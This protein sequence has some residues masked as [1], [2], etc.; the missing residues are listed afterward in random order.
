MKTM[1]NGMDITTTMDDVVVS[2]RIPKNK[3]AS[4]MDELNRLQDQ[5]LDVEIKKHRNKRSLNANNYAWQLIHKIAEVTGEDAEEVYRRYIRQSGDPEIIEVNENAVPKF[6]EAWGG[7]GIGWIV[8]VLDYSRTEGMKI[9]RAF[10]G[11]STYNTK[12]MSRYIDSVVEDAKSLGIET[13]TPCE[14]EGLKA[15]WQQA[16]GRK[17]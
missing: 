13:M 6:I 4:I 15:A 17:Q 8:D 1:I 2:I 5:D 12:Q 16:D 11:S 9:V 3:A 10:Y 7:N 14:L